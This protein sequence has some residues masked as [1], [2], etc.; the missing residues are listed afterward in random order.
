MFFFA[1]RY[2]LEVLNGNR[3]DRYRAIDV[4]TACT[5]YYN[6]FTEKDR[7]RFNNN[8]YSPK[9]MVHNKN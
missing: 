1:S 5:V 2:T 3:Y 7:I 6:E 9:Y 4:H 8:L